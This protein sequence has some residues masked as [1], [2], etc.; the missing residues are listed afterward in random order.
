[1]I[2]ANGNLSRRGPDF[3]RTQN[4]EI[5]GRSKSGFFHDLLR[6]WQIVPIP[7]AL[8]MDLEISRPDRFRR[9]LPIS[10]P[11]DVLRVHT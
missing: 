7:L 6:P 8:P 4:R 9:I 1:M 5:Q 3:L 2:T 11:G 10:A